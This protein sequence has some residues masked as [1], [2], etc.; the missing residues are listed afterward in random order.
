MGN[1]CFMRTN[2]SQKPVSEKSSVRAMAGIALRL[3][4]VLLGTQSLMDGPQ[5]ADKTNMMIG[6][7]NLKEQ[8]NINGRMGVELNDYP[9]PGANNRHTPSRG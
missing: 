3:L 7:E 1:A 8:A 9:G 6:V 5:L 2:N 4:V